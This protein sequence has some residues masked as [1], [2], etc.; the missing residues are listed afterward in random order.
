MSLAAFIKGMNM[1]EIELLLDNLNVWGELAIPAAL[2]I[3]NLEQIKEALKR[4]QRKIKDGKKGGDAAERFRGGGAGGVQVPVGGFG[5]AAGAGAGAAA[6][7]ASGAGRGGRDAS[8]AA[9]G[10]GAIEI[11]VE[12][13]P[14]E[15]KEPDTRSEGLR[16]R[17][18]QSRPNIGHAGVDDADSQRRVQEGIRDALRD[19][20][21][22]DVELGDMPTGGDGSKEIRTRSGLRIPRPTRGQLAAGGGLAATIALIPKL[23]P[24]STVKKKYIDGSVDVVD[25]NGNK[26]R[27]DPSIFVNGM[28][29]KS[30]QTKGTNDFYIK[31]KYRTPRQGRWNTELFHKYT[32]VAAEYANPSGM[33]RSRR[34]T[35]GGG[36]I[37]STGRRIE[38]DDPPKPRNL[39]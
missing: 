11:V 25:K 3:Y 35:T 14:E 12:D 28:S 39:I 16:S 32:D 15:T 38:L 24:G 29:G 6:G 18:K 36:S 4:A 21:M 9:G 37:K 8:S 34:N 22:R 19:P 7:V 2:S 33:N 27:I 10:S 23:W 30:S 5:A 26:Y 31:N 1:G 17:G 13:P 20:D